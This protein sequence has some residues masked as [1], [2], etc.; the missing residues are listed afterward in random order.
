MPSPRHHIVVEV[1]DGRMLAAGGRLSSFA[2]NL[3][4]T[5]AEDAAADS[6]AQRVSMSVPRS[7]IAAMSYQGRICVFGRE[8]TGG[9]FNENEVY[10]PV[11]DAWS[12][13]Q[14]LPTARHGLGS[15]SVGN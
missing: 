13:A 4:V 3:R 1:V 6:W 14:P 8:A 7:G 10:H 9:A 11:V 2:R 15:A 5:E 12:L